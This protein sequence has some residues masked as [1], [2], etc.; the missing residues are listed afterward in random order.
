LVPKAPVLALTRDQL[1]VAPTAVK[2][3]R[4][5]PI[6]L[7]VVSVACSK[8]NPVAPTADDGEQEAVDTLVA[9][10]RPADVRVHN[11]PVTM[12]GDPA[13]PLFYVCETQPRQYCGTSC[14]WERDHYIS[15]QQC[16]AVPVE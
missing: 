13:G 2:W 1:I 9:Q 5:L 15:R 4:F 10:M 12:E 6:L 16:P 7:L 14:T 11:L 3:M 8:A